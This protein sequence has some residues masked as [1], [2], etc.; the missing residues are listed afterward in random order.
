MFE[1]VRPYLACA[2]QVKFATSPWERRGA[3]ELRR[4][5]FCEEQ[6][7]FGGDDRDAIDAVSIPIVALA[8]LSIVDDEVAGTV[9]IHE[10]EPGLWWGSRLAVAPAYRRVGALGAALIRL[11]VSSAH[12]RGCH[13]FLAHVQAQNAPLFHRVHWETLEVVDLHGRPHHRMRADLAHYPPIDDAET[14]FLSLQSV[15]G[16]R[17]PARARGAA[18]AA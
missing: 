13:T 8:S 5:V 1:P 14:G 12:A 18:V 4:R 2:Y 3:A 9:R 15:P 16:R 11:A 6:G 17:Q 7:L 10:P